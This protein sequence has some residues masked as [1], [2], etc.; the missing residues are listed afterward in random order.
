[1][2]M[3]CHGQYEMANT[4][5]ALMMKRVNKCM[6]GPFPRGARAPCRSVA[7]GEAC[8]TVQ[9]RGDRQHRCAAGG[10][11]RLVGGDVRSICYVDRSIWPEG[12]IVR[13]V[14]AVGD[15]ERRS[16]GARDRPGIDGDRI[17]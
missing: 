6:G 5:S 17:A 1:M 14:N 8:G 3:M 9:S 4:A 15:H 13:R 7:D 12:H 10:E 2:P 11:W 16:T